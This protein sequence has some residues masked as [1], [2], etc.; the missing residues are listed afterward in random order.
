MLFDP[1]H[2]AL[3]MGRLAFP[4]LVIQALAPS[5][6]TWLLVG[7][8]SLMLAVLAAVALVNVACTVGLWTMTQRNR[9]RRT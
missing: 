7:D 8:G 5:I 2:Y 6:G 9:Q 4:S 1:A 3:F